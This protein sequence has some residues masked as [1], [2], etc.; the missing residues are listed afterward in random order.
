M[1]HEKPDRVNLICENLKEL[2]QKT[3]NSDRVIRIDFSMSLKGFIKP[4]K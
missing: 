3:L 2:A 1:N 4:K